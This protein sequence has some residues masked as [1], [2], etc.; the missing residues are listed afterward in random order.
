MSAKQTARWKALTEHGAGR[1]EA[2]DAI[3][4]VSE[5]DGWLDKVRE[6]ADA[7]WNDDIKEMLLEDSVSEVQYK[8]WRAAQKAGVKL[9]TYT[10]FL[11][12]AYRAARRRTGKDSAW[13][14]PASAPIQMRDR[15]TAVPLE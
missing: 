5:A 4:E 12:R 13:L 15:S 7:P 6:I 11:D 2:F 3:R 9:I 8:R 10:D 1:Q 14:R